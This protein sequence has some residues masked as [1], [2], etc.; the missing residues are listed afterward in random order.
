[1]MRKLVF[2]LPF[3]LSGCILLYPLAVSVSSAGVMATAAKSGPGCLNAIHL[4]ERPASRR[5]AQIGPDKP[6]IW[7]L[8]ALP[9]RC[10]S[11]FPVFRY[12]EV[13]QGMRQENAPPALVP[14]RIYWLRGYTS[15]AV[16]SGEFA[17]PVPAGGR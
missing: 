2:L 12:G 7:T 16:Y 6:P 8:E 11:G 15:G 10:I 5:Q 3:A 13:P 4:F 9:G 14:G 1:M 17:A